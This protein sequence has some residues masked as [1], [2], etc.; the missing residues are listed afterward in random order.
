MLCSETSSATYHRGTYWLSGL[1]Y[2]N[3]FPIMI[4]PPTQDYLRSAQISLPD[5]PPS[6]SIIIFHV[7]YHLAFSDLSASIETHSTNSSQR[8]FKQAKLNH[9]CLTQVTCYSITLIYFLNNTHD[10]S[11]FLK[12]F[13]WLL[14]VY[15][16]PLGHEFHENKDLVSLESL[17]PRKVFVT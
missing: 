9:P 5:L 12:L 16:F 7:N 15:L 11:N 1:K 13:T 14:I 6:E 4:E 10:L 8:W 3:C 17:L 2:T